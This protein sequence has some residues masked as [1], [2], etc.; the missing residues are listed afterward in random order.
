MNMKRLLLPGAL[1]IAG[2]GGVVGGSMLTSL[3]AHAAT[4]SSTTAGTT[5]AA[6]T[7]AAATTDNSTTTTKFTSNEDPTHEAGESAAREAQETAGQMPT[8][9]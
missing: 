3:S 7:T 6:A 8:V 2:F 9:Q 1:A 4:T 5:T